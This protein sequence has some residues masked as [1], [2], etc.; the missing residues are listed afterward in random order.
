MKQL[1]GIYCSDGIAKDNTRFTI[2]ALEDM[3]WQGSEGRPLGISHDFHRFIG[4][5]VITG[6][7]MSHEQSY[8]VGNSFL[9]EDEQDMK[10]L[11][12]LRDGFYF[13][14]LNK[15]FDKYKDEFLSV[16]SERGLTDIRAQIMYVGLCIY[17]YEGILYKAFP[18]IKSLCDSDYLIKLDDLIINFK[19]LGQ[20]I[21]A[22]EGSK[23]AI[24]LHP[25]FRRSFSRYNNY[26]FGFLDSLW[27]VYQNGNKSIKV[28]LDPDFIGY[29]PSYTQ[30]FEHE[31]W[32]GP[33][34]NDEIDTI[35]EGL[36]HLE[37]EDDLKFYNNIKSTE[38]IWQKKDNRRKYQFEMEEIV[39]VTSP[40]LSNDTYGCRYLHALYDFEKSEFEHFD[41]AVRSYE[42]SQ[43]VERMYTPMDKM[44][45][46]TKYQKIFRMDGHIPL[47]QWKGLITQYL[48]SNPLVY[49]YFK[50]PRP[51][52]TKELKNNDFIEDNWNDYI[53]FTIN[54]GDGVR[55]MASYTNDVVNNFDARSFI[56]LDK[57]MLYNSEKNDIA[58][59]ATIEVVKAIKKVGAEIKLPENIVYYLSD[60]FYHYIPCIHHASVNLSDNIY[61]TIQGIKLLVGQHVKNR[62]KDR[63]SFSV[64]WNSEG[65]RACISF[66]GHVNDLHEW[67]KTF[68]SI[69]TNRKDL[70]LWL[71]A[72]NNFIHNHGNNSI[73][74]IN[75]SLIRSDGVLFFK[76]HDITEYVI[77]TSINL[78]SEHGYK[79]EISID[80][81][82]FLKENLMAGRLIVVP[83]F[84]VYDAFDEK[85]KKSYLNTLYS[86]VF[87]ETT[88]K[89]DRKIMGFNFAMK[90]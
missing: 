32:Y 82:N 27:N 74:Q 65:K 17:G 71:D 84:I 89:L 53:P 8:V 66:M 73:S 10:K 63:Y 5:N 28:L 61:K 37:N 48:C 80:N 19:Y 49:D 60:D 81:N 54:L 79:G 36:C 25:Y 13:N 11:Q 7:Y 15:M 57:T 62:D 51:F 2:S 34:Y 23:L 22:H 31:Y 44:G 67:L 42:H 26:N 68:E 56:N 70:K 64:S 69:P 72:Q 40:I 50:I 90:F 14:M 76:R 41:G 18:E 30:C 46:H 4:W 58:E 33:V 59:F 52:S 77:I 75:N 47:H 55:L 39:D 86:Q 20:G 35:P 85:C 21:F 9:P 38:F 1:F 3:V 43:M 83:R 45:H 78:D 24:L 16:L 87:N 29:A 6:L 88:Y 12:T